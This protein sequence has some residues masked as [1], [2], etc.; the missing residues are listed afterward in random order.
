MGPNV[1]TN[2]SVV[3]CSYTI[4]DIRENNIKEIWFSERVGKYTSQCKRPCLQ[5]YTI[6][7]SASNS[8]KATYFMLKKK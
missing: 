1:V 4:G 7:F 5:H 6:R 2:G 8:L 3:V